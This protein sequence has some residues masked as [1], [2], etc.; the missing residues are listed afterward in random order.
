M[1]TQRN[2]QR[3]LGTTEVS[4][5]GRSR[6]TTRWIAQVTRM[7]DAERE[8]E[9]EQRDRLDRLERQGVH[10]VLEVV[11]LLRRHPDQHDRQQQQ[12]RHQEEPD[13]QRDRADDR[14]PPRI[15]PGAEHLVVGLRLGVRERRVRRGG[16]GRRVRRVRRSRRQVLL[17]RRPR[18]GPARCLLVRHPRV[19]VSQP[20]C[21][22]LS[23]ASE[24][25]RPSSSN[26]SNSGGD[27]RLPVTATRT[28]PNA[29]PRLEPEL[30]DEGLPQR[31]VDRLGGPRVE[32]RQRVVRGLHDA[33]AVLVE[34]LRRRRP[35]RG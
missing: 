14:L 27:T 35:G 33:A 30:L 15:G 5:R 32:C 29:L 13:E 20:A 19:L 9:V 6:C 34:Q 7:I 16:R 1:Q 17:R 21:A 26:D 31:G 25:S 11:A 12:R 22:L 24:R 2:F 4:Q 23:R 8:V 28:G 18:R 10:E 3:S